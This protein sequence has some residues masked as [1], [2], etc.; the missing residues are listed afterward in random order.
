MA[1]LETQLAHA[2][3]VSTAATLVADQLRQEVQALIVASSEHERD[4]E[5]S[6]E[7]VCLVWCGGW[8][9]FG[10]SRTYRL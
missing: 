8:V 7:E 1:E 6:V 3:E 4:F 9:D 5:A 10:S 2:R